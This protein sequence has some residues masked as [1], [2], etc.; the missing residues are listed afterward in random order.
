[1]M[2]RDGQQIGHICFGLAIC[3]VLEV[4]FSEAG[5]EVEPL[6]C[7][8]GQSDSSCVEMDSLH[9]HIHAFVNR[10]QWTKVGRCGESPIH[11][12]SSLVLYWIGFLMTISLMVKEEELKGFP[13]RGKNVA[14]WLNDEGLLSILSLRNQNLLGCLLALVCRNQNHVRMEGSS[15]VG[16]GY[17]L[18]THAC[19]NC[20]FNSQGLWI[21][22]NLRK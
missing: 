5:K 2:A 13:W 1:M 12:L 19:A 22:M 14:K 21:G 7:W 20:K 8:M 3:V 15:C 18:N 17:A 16:L 11:I 6:C 4:V 10:N 9:S